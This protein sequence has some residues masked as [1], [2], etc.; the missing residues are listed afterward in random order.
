LGTSSSVIGAGVLVTVGA[1]VGEDAIVA[2]APKIEVELAIGDEVRSGSFAPP[3]R[4]VCV[5]MVSKIESSGSEVAVATEAEVAERVQAAI[6]KAAS[7]TRRTLNRLFIVWENI[8]S[9]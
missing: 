5:A 8:Y 4:A 1:V 9:R 7:N 3:A 2:V 6:S